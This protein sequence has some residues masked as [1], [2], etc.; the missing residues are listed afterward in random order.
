MNILLAES[1]EDIFGTIKP[2]NGVTPLPTGINSGDLSPIITFL[3][4]I[5]KLAISA[6][7]I[8]ALVNFII[9]GYQ[10]MTAGG[11]AKM[12]EK[13]WNRIWQTFVGLLIIV[14]SFLIAAV[15]GLLLFGDPTAI[16]MPHL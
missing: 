16:L 6:A 4:N 13:A 2:P 14:C 12:V 9:A 5:M 8:W 10:F 15:M 7:G 3:N 11:D 1:V